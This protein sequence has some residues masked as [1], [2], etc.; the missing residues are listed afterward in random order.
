MRGVIKMGGQDTSEGSHNSQHRGKFTEDLLDNERILKAL[1]IRAGQIIVDAGCGNGYMSKLFSKRVGPSGRVYA[2]DPDTHS[3]KVLRD[4]TQGTNIETIEGDITKPTLVKKS[5]VDL[6]YISAVIHAF[7][8]DQMQ[9]FLQE[10]K[11][12]LKPGA[13]LAIVEIEKKKTP[14]GPPLELRYSPEELRETVP[15]VPV[16]T[17]KAGEHFYMQIFRK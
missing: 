17:V 11:R 13:M 9:G 12:L 14:F 5:S 16:N 15:L 8:K 4:E 7:S 2:L 3:I 1:N 10:V 6:I